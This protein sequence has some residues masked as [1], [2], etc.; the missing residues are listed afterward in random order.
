LTRFRRRSSMRPVAGF[1]R[2]AAPIA[3]VATRRSE[4]VHRELRRMS[5]RLPAG[6]VRSR[7]ERQCS[8]ADRPERGE[9]RVQ[10]PHLLGSMGVAARA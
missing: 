1:A 4:L 10:P 6:P 7:D 9:S 5:V 3:P 8:R 2:T